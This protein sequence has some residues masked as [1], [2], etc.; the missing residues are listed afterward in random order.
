MVVNLATMASADFC[1]S[2]GTSLDIPS[3]RQID[4]SPRVMRVTFL[5][6]TRH[7]YN[8][9]LPDDYWALKRVAFSPG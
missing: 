5:P 1:R 2:I 8:P 3:T 9:I 7:I 6:Y 4:R